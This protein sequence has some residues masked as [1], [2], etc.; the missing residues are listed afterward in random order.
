MNSLEQSKRANRRSNSSG[1]SVSVAKLKP[2]I[3][4]SEAWAKEYIKREQRNR[5]RGAHRE[6]AHFADLVC[7]HQN[8]AG[9]LRQLVWAAE[10]RRVRLGDALSL[11]RLVSEQF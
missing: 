10:K 9:S 4:D 1:G 2:L 7:A 8:F 3:E 11:R 6:A 5:D